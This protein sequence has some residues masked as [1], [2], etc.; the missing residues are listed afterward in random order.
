V[1]TRK[2]P[3]ESVTVQTRKIG[4]YRNIK[5]VE[6]AAEFLLHSWPKE[7]GRLELVARIACLNALEGGLPGDVAREAFVMAAK[8]AGILVRAG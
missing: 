2:F 4:L 3:F 5:S 7:K 6:E 1:L 8:E